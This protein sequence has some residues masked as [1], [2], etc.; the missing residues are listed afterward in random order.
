[1]PE[2]DRF[3]EIVAAPVRVLPEPMASVPTV[4]DSPAVARMSTF[5]TVVVTVPSVADAPPVR[6]RKEARLP[7]VSVHEVSAGRTI[8][9]KAPS[10]DI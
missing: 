3:P 7:F 10:A 9:L 5:V 1:M 8:A 2:L 6:S 4:M